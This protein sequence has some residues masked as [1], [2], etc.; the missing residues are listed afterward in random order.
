MKIYLKDFYWHI[1]NAHTQTHTPTT[2]HKWSDHYSNF[3]I[4]KSNVWLRLFKLA[5]RTTRDIKI[6]SFQYRIIHKF[7]PCNKWFHNLKI[8]NSDSC[9]FC[10]G[11]DDVPHYFINAAPK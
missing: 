1:V 9:D 3:N 6:Q 2:V 5:F 7:I 11:K 8:N 4:S 10:E